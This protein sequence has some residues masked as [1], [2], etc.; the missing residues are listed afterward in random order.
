MDCAKYKDM[1]RKE[2]IRTEVMLTVARVFRKCGLKNRLMIRS[3]LDASFPYVPHLGLPAGRCSKQVL[4]T[5]G[6]R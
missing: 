2:V 1:N 4:G 5:Q 6:R 3:E